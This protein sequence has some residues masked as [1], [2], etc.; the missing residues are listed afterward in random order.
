MKILVIGSVLGAVVLGSLFF[1]FPKEI[2][3]SAQPGT[4][5][6]Q[7]AVETLKDLIG[8]PEHAAVPI[9]APATN[10]NSSSDAPNQA[11]LPNPPSIV[12]AIYITSWS[13]GSPSKI[14]ALIDLIKRTELNAAVID[15]KDYSGYVAY[16][17]DV[18]EIRASGALDQLRILRPNNLIKRL[19]DEN[20]YVIGRISVF[21]DPILAKAH[22]EWA[23]KNKT[24]GKPWTD[25]KG[26]AWMDPAA[27]PVWD[28]NIAIA[29]DAL[30]RGFDELNFDYIRFPSDGDMGNMAYPLWDEKSLRQ[31]VIKKFFAYIRES[32]P[33]GVLSADLFGLTTVN[34]D[35]LGIGQVIENAYQYFDYVSPMVYPSHYAPGFL[36]FKNPADH[37]Y[38]VVHYSL[39]RAL[40]RLENNKPQTASGTVSAVSST[41]LRFSAR[42]RPWLQDFNLG[43]T[44]DA[45]MVK[46]Q[47]QAVT[48]VL[49]GASS[50][51]QFTGWLLWDPSNNYTEGALAH[52]N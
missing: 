45:A 46:K 43:A 44:Y 50:T 15:I 20:I 21:Q 39:E 38:E 19:H 32:L 41:Q 49:G 37:P 5:N 10:H 17:V 9:A 26:L 30:S 2:L 12:K 31:S 4:K 7:T 1:L 14:N 6:T 29:K 36:G 8:A 27:R 24:T 52:E 47:M 48:D 25:R 35:D 42:L 18:P 34:A 28:Y 33:G 51:G 3:V 16:A 23:V 11:R 40:A 13:A 22:P